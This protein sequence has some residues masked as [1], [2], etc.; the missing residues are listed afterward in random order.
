MKQV[1]AFDIHR[2]M[3]QYCPTSIILEDTVRKASGRGS[4]SS[5]GPG[6]LAAPG[7]K[8]PLRQDGPR[9]STALDLTPK[10]CK[11]TTQTSSRKSPPHPR[12]P[13]EVTARR[14]QDSPGRALRGGCV[15]WSGL[16][17]QHTAPF[18]AEAVAKHCPLGDVQAAN[19]ALSPWL[20]HPGRRE[21]SYQ[22][23]CSAQSPRY[24][25]SKAP[26]RT[27]APAQPVLSIPHPRAHRAATAPTG[28]REQAQPLDQLGQAHGSGRATLCRYFPL[29]LVSHLT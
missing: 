3:I 16:H 19:S 4:V 12:A 28:R 29:F 5:R 22:T 2:G 6:C 24:K 25:D 27:Q 21:V 15:A 1:Q 26:G 17:S 20:T 10:P 8:A 23:S 9:L 14:Q 13:A 11:K 18:Q 7:R